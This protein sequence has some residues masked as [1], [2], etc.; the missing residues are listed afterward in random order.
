MDVGIFLPGGVALGA[1]LPSVDLPS[2]DLPSSIFD[3]QSSIRDSLPVP[4]S[5]RQFPT[6]P[7]SDT[8]SKGALS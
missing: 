2:V 4:Q 1:A 5:Q 6:P 3:P 7:S 8:V